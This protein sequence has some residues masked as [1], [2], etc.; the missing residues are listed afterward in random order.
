MSAQEQAV[1]SGGQMEMEHAP[2]YNTNAATAHSEAAVQ[3]NAHT[4]AEAGGHGEQQEEGIPELEN[5]LDYYLMAKTGEDLHTIHN[6]VLVGKQPAPGEEPSSMT[7]TWLDLINVSYAFLTI[8]ILTVISLRVKSKLTKIPSGFQV[9]VEAFVQWMDGFVK[10]IIGHDG[11]KFTPFIG[12]IFIYILFMNYLGLIPFMKAPIALNINVPLSMAICV[13]FLVQYRGITQN[14][15]VKYIK[16]FTGDSSGMVVLDVLLMPLNLV[17]HTIGEIAKPL[18][19]SLR[20]FGN[21]TGEDVVI[22]AL[23]GLTVGVTFFPIPLQALF[24]PLALLFGFIQ[25]LVFATLSAVYIL[26][27]SAHEEHH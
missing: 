26:L 2:A 12:T 14:G 1:H 23:V 7:L 4:G 24:Y 18:T 15:L 10:A 6:T 17:L 16:H 21:I 20:L 19:L 3:G 8:I 5:F 11:R 25:A 13:F 9:L 27:M 22:A